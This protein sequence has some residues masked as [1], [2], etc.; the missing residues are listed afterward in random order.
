MNIKKSIKEINDYFVEKIL[1]EEFKVKNW[2][3]SSDDTVWLKIEI[4]GYEFCL[5]NCTGKGE[6][7]NSTGECF[8]ELIFTQKQ[9]KAINKMLNRIYD[10]KGKKAKELAERAEYER[11]KLT[12]GAKK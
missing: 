2:R 9:S 8:M 7:Y 5:W 10:D 11:L 3:K 6:P 1:N 4:G 12:Y